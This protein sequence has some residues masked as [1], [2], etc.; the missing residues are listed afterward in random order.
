MLSHG[1]HGSK[2]KT[3]ALIYD[4]DAIQYIQNILG[5]SEGNAD[6]YRKAF[7]KNKLHMKQQFKTQSDMKTD[8]SENEK[9][10]RYDS[11]FK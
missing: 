6:L 1:Y 4:D 8:Y 5:C 3:H 10:K 11:K 9:K 7:S 2:N